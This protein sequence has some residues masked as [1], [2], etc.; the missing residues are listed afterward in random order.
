MA[1]MYRMKAPVYTA[2]RVPERDPMVAAKDQEEQT[3]LVAQWVDSVGGVVESI[4]RDSIAI[5]ANPEEQL[6]DKTKIFAEPGYWILRSKKNRWWL[7]NDA[8]FQSLFEKVENENKPVP[9]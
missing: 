8:Y 4:N 7:A 1:D 3:R 2:M 9:D 5:L 6:I